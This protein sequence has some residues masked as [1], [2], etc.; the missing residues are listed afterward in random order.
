MFVL[1]D[2]GHSCCF[3]PDGSAVVVG[4]E[5]GRWVAIDTSTHN[6]VAEHTDGNEQIECCLFSPGNLSYK[7]LNQL[8]PNLEI[9]MI[10]NI[11]NLLRK[12]LNYFFF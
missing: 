8:L 4:M 10:L 6:I 11:K 3:S 12:S 1:Q 7:L 2:P 5:T 9:Q